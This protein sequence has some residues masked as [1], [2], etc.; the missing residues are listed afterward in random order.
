MLQNDKDMKKSIFPIIALFGA[1]AWTGCQR[2]EEPVPQE[3]PGEEAVVWMTTVQASK[4]ADAGTKALELEEDKT[5]NAYW[6][7]GER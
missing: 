2:L 5:L 7:S 3:E 4:P 6:K 1:L